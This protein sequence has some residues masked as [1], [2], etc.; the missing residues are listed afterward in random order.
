MNK[1]TRTF[2]YYCRSFGQPYSPTRRIVQGQLT[3]RL[4][5]KSLRRVHSKSPRPHRCIDSGMLAQYF[6]SIY[7]LEGLA[8]DIAYAVVL[9]L[10][11]LAFCLKNCSQWKVY[12]KK[13]KVGNTDAVSAHSASIQVL[14][15]SISQRVKYFL[16]LSIHL[17]I[18]SK[19]KFFKKED[20]LKGYVSNGCIT[21]QQSLI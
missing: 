18:L 7:C 13:A 11:N 19:F 15:A 9:G 5:G 3:N 6:L 17:N 16:K 2:F 4:E 8:F 20:W 10:M 21:L 14:L 1:Y 12:Y